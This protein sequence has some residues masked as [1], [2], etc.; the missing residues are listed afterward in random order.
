MRQVAV[1][2]AFCALLT[3]CEQAPAPVV[4]HAEDAIPDRLG[5]WGVVMSNGQFLQ[6]NDGVVPYGLNTPLFTDY[7]LKLRT[8]WLPEG[9]TATY[10][11]DRE[12]DFPVGTI[13]SKTFHYEK[14]DGWSNASFEVVKADRE[15]MLDS[16]GQLSLTDYVLMETRLLVRY[17]DGWKAL[18]YVWNSTQDEAFLEVAGDYRDIELVDAEGTQAIS[19]IVPDANQCAGCHTP[20]HTSKDMAPLGPRG[21]QLNRSY[22]YGGALENQLDH[23]MAAGILSG[24]AESPLA[25]VHWRDPGDATLEER[26]KA[27][28]DA[29]CAHCHNPAGA[30][31]TS[32]L[33][34]NIDAPVDRNYGI[35]KTPVA[36]GRGSGD[37]TY[38]IYP[39]RPDESIVVYRMQHTDP[40][41]AMPEL[42]R[43]AVHVEGVEIISNWINAMNGEC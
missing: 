7:A 27:Y 19:Y 9:T 38:D 35:C 21:W 30:A 37:H 23:W 2:A 13:I 32:A 42:G 18:P 24:V 10:N 11:P 4:V 8:V 28:L 5:D 43:S 16:N 14:T 41:I 40:A 17:E 3:A 33:H 20:D 31:D 6:L 25:G 39:G 12:L 26:A 29:N 34:L 1:F 22:A 36:V 15:S